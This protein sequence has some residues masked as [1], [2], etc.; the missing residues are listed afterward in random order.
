MPT[1]D[2]LAATVR[3]FQEGGVSENPAAATADRG[4][5][6]KQLPARGD[7]EML[8]LGIL[9][10][11]APGEKGRDFSSDSVALR[12]NTVSRVTAAMAAGRL[13]IPR[14]GNCED[15]R[16][17]TAEY[18]VHDALRAFTALNDKALTSR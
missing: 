18:A 11:P 13:K 17:A 12:N 6:Y 9:K 1:W 7:R 4:E 2:H 15:S 16:V 14:M 5:A 3:T 10:D 8:A